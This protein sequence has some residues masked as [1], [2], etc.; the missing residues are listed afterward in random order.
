MANLRYVDGL[1]FLSICYTM[2]RLSR[3]DAFFICPQAVLILGGYVLLSPWIAPY[4]IGNRWLQ[5][6]A[7]LAFVPC[8]SRPT[9]AWVLNECKTSLKMCCVRTQN[10]DLG[11]EWA[12][13]CDFPCLRYCRILTFMLPLHRQKEISNLERS[14]FLDI[15]F[16]RFKVSRL[17]HIGF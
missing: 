11:Q 17:F 15:R 1:R 13:K 5:S 12:Q 8:V 4:Y 6:L 9:A 3:T 2:D 10:V 7:S 14:E 16:N